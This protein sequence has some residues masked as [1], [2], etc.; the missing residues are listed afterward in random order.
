MT[1]S[2]HTCLV[3]RHNAGKTVIDIKVNEF[4]EQLKNSWCPIFQYHSLCISKNR[5]FLEYLRAMLILFLKSRKRKYVQETFSISYMD[6][7]VEAV[8]DQRAL[9]Q[10]CQL[11]TNVSTYSL[12]PSNYNS[13]CIRLSNNHQAYLSENNPLSV[14]LSALPSCTYNPSKANMRCH[15]T[16]LALKYLSLF[17]PQ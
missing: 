1:F 2:V 3:H 5:P 12:A 7:V 13:F 8:E 16:P 6:K 15:E 10:L 14:F 11:L 4:L 9:R 17:I